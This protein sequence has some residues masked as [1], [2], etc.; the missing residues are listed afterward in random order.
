[1]DTMNKGRIL[2]VDD[3]PNVLSIVRSYLLK[4][5][6]QALE[7]Q[8]GRKALEVFQ[9]EKPDLIVLDIMLP[10]IDGMDVLREIRK[11]SQTPVIL[12]TARA[13]DADKL[14][15]LELG[16][17]DYV[18]KPFSPR[19]L[20]ARVKAVLRRAQKPAGA[21]SKT[22]CIGAMTIDPER[23]EITCH[24]KAVPVTATEFRILFALGE[25]AGRV[26]TRQQ[27]L[28]RAFDMAYEGYDR[29]VDAHIKNIRRKLADASGNKGCNIATVQGV[30]YKLEE[31][32]CEE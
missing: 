28:D 21:E 2:V 27:L 19:E 9:R 8:D 3:E 15:G 31:A 20:V 32:G 7:A 1:M 4:E 13:E 6:Y 29:T 23:F 10:E 25:S 12:L 17:D 26:L 18:V 5:G 14:V 24:G 11:S 16:A 22:L 30:G